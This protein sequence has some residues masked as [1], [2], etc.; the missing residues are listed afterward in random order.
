MYILNRQRSGRFYLYYCRT[1]ENISAPITFALRAGTASI[2]GSLLAFLRVFSMSEESLDHWLQ[3][4]HC[5]NLKYDEC[6]VETEVE[7]KCWTFLNGRC[8]LLLRLYR[9]TKD[10][11]RSLSHLI[12]LNCCHQI[13]TVVFLVIIRPFF[14]ADLQEDLQLL[15]TDLNVHQR[16]C[17]LLRL[18]EKRIL[19]ST[20]EYASNKIKK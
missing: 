13:N 2:D 6:G 15:Q 14:G 11:Q 9:T 8:Q 7:D 4:Q 18:A 16:L 12:H 10:V 19:F 17:V 20:M 5:S 1:D 3:H